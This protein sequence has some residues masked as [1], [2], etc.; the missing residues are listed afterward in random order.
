MFLLTIHV[1]SL[2]VEELQYFPQG[3]TIETIDFY[4]YKK[5][6]SHK[7]KGTI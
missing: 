7:K 3:V 4:S 5:N 6:T 2:T 1:H